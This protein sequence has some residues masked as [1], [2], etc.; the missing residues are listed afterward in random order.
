MFPDNALNNDQIIDTETLLGTLDTQ[1]EQLIKQ[2]TRKYDKDSEDRY[3]YLFTQT[4]KT[5]IETK[6]AGNNEDV[7][8][9]PSFEEY[10]PF[11][12]SI[13]DYTGIT[14]DP[15][16]VDTSTLV[17]EETPISFESEASIFNDMSAMLE[18]QLSVIENTPM[19]E[20]TGLF[21]G[22]SDDELIAI[23][24]QKKEHDKKCNR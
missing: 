3:S 21:N 13:T 19:I 17:I 2:Q 22:M 23:N 24:E 16:M 6:I 10:T 14:E 9:D 20:D 4:D 8:I 12:N 15:T 18:Q 1:K 5:F 11:D 7:F